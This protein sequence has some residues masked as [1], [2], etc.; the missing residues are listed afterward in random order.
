MD[1]VTGDV[2]QRVAQAKASLMAADSNG[3]SVYDHLHDLIATMMEENPGDIAANPDLIAQFSRVMKEQG[4]NYGESSAATS[5]STKAAAVHAIIASRAENDLALLSKEPTKE[6]RTVVERPNPN[7]IV[8]TTKTSSTRTPAFTSVVRQNTFWR[9]AGVGLA[10]IEARLLDQSIGQL[11]AEKKLKEVRFFGK[12]FGSHADYIVVTSQRHVEESE[13]PMTEI[14][15]MPA[16]PAR[17]NLDIEVQ[18]EPP[19]KGCNRLSF[20]VCSQAG[21]SWVKLPDITPQQLNAARKVRKLFS[22]DLNAP[23]IA[24]PAFGWNEAVLLRAQLSRLVSATYVTPAG[25]AENYEPPEDDEEEEYDEDEL[26][27]KPRPAKYKPLTQNVKDYA[28]PDDNIR[29]LLDLEQWVHAESYIYQTGRHTKVPQRPDP[30]DD[31]PEDEE[32]QEEEDPQNEPEEEEEKDLFGPVRRDTLFSVIKI[33]Q[34]PN[35]EEEEE[36]Q[37][38]ED[39]EEEENQG[40]E[41]DED[42]NPVDTNAPEKPKEDDDVPDDDPLQKKIFPWQTRVANMTY[43]KHG[44][45]VL[46]S[47]RW[48][49]AVAFAAQGGKAW[50]CVYFGDGVKAADTN[51]S[52]VLAPPIIG[53]AKDLTEAQDPTAANEKLVL[54]GEDPKEADSEDDREDE[55]EEDEE[56]QE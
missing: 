53:E 36:N 16:K 28:V 37:E 42:G 51:F 18:A 26:L 55:P 9:S 24:Y 39:N 40:P 17:K 54:R 2:E 49:G 32:E 34:E 48:P 22:G 23:V 33:P 4:F 25:A 56:G 8:T 13:V 10:D 47:I 44:V 20:W 19:Y 35:P 41:L 15:T 38:E 12:I 45:C 11:A 1:R 3:R 27:R 14:N 7:T 31:A 6:T 43:K 30:E 46:R 5:N 29:S 50:G 21:A 52:P